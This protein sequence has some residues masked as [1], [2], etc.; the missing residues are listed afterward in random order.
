MAQSGLVRIKSR[1][2][3]K[4]AK[5][6]RGDGGIA[7][8]SETFLN[9][10]DP[11]AS[12]LINARLRDAGAFADRCL[13][14]WS[15]FGNSLNFLAEANVNQKDSREDLEFTNDPFAGGIICSRGFF[16][17]TCAVSPLL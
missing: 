11:L 1:G 3:T 2:G 15:F 4:F 13:N 6:C 7:R 16:L 9:H 5:F 17:C 8:G 10:E 12:E 14:L